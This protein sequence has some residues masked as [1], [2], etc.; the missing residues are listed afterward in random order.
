VIFHLLPGYCRVFGDFRVIDS[1]L[2]KSWWKLLHIVHIW[3]DLI[4]FIIE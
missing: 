4:N 3:P 1:E 2:Y